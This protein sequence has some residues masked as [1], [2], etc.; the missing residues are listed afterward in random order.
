VDFLLSGPK[1]PDDLVEAI[2][3]RSRDS[4]RDIEF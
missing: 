4:G 1:W 2:S 3:E